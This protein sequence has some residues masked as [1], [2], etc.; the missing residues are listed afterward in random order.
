[1]SARHG[2]DGNEARRV[3]GLFWAFVLGLLLVAVAITVGLVFKADIRERPE[4]PAKTPFY[5]RL[6]VALP[7][8][9]RGLDV[10]VETARADM[11][12]TVSREVDRAFE[13][14]YARI[15]VFLDHHYSVVGEYIELAA[16]ASD[17]I[18]SRLQRIL[19][20]ES[21][22][23]QRVEQ[24]LAKI[25]A[26]NLQHVERLLTRLRQRLQD[27]LE[28][29]DPQLLVLSDLARL[30]LDDAVAR[31]ED[32]ALAL[33]GVG[34]AVGGGAVGA[35]LAKT[36][37][38]KAV[39]KLAAKTAGKTALKSAG[40]GGS[41]SAGA[42]I[43]LLCGPAAWICAPL[44]AIGGAAIGWLAVD[45]VVVEADELLNRDEFEAE[46]SAL[47]DA[48]RQR[49]KAELLEHYQRG[50]D[51]VLKSAERSLEEV[52]RSPLKETLQQ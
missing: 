4:A 9:F 47:L 8:V 25:A 1:M 18:D 6:E 15:P 52:V 17:L 45:K 29:S 27:E 5:E 23:E 31:F 43:G 41:A 20:E 21:G 38:T 36:V 37:G 50:I 33:K 46:I 26:A 49:V 40:A 48:E 24:A 39:A 22:F 13:P 32:T 44:G 28:L 2:L 10:D 19:I 35:A 14:I 30:T 3:N 7:E 34:A 12:S 42:G 51:E 11:D 16:A